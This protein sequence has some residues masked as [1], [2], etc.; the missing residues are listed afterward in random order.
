MRAYWLTAATA[1]LLA[2]SPESGDTDT[3]G[4]AAPLTPF[5]ELL[6][7][8]PELTPQCEDERGSDTAM[9]TPLPC[10]TE[11]LNERR[12]GLYTVEFNVSGDHTAPHRRTFAIHNDGSVS[13]ICESLFSGEV[14]ETNWR[15]DYV[16][17]PQDLVLWTHCQCWGPGAAACH[18]GT[19]EDE[20]PPLSLGTTNVLA[21]CQPTL[22]C[23]GS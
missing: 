15:C 2:C 19:P 5:D 17:Q 7:C 3:T 13:T 22:T 21:G 12:P 4:E 6:E 20:Q 9:H 14:L 16:P 11:A 10:L 18:V 8:E 1:A 23:P